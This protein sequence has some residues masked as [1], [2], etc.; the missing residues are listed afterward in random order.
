MEDKEAFEV[1]LSIK[2]SK[3]IYDDNRRKANGDR[4][5]MSETEVRNIMQNN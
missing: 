2:D 3:R 4:Y 5:L 1:A